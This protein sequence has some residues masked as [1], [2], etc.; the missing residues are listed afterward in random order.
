[1]RS[2]KGPILT[3]YAIHLLKFQDHYDIRLGNSIW[4]FLHMRTKERRYFSYLVLGLSS[5]NTDTCPRVAEVR[6]R[7]LTAVP[8][9]QRAVEQALTLDSL[10]SIRVDAQILGVSIDFRALFHRY[11]SVEF[12]CTVNIDRISCI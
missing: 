7:Q 9:S 3:D 12:C 1:M 11:V 5:A 6:Q 8:T 4:L 2:K 10:F